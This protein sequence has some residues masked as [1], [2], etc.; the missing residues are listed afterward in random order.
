[1]EHRVE[2][3]VESDLSAFERLAVFF[4]VHFVKSVP[5]DVTLHKISRFL[6]LKVDFASGLGVVLEYWLECWF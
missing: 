3:W 4:I 6:H 5:L 2:D 1:L